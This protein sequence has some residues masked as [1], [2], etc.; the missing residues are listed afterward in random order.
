MAL[1]QIALRSDDIKRSHGLE[2]ISISEILRD[3]AAT[4]EL[5]KL[6]EEEGVLVSNL[7][8]HTI[9]TTTE[10]K[11]EYR[12]CGVI[13]A[14]NDDNLIRNPIDTM[15]IR[16]LNQCT[17]IL[18]GVEEQMHPGGRIVLVTSKSARIKKGGLC[19]LFSASNV[20]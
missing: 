18:S 6:Q 11:Q 10:P 19:V 16:A 2:I 7:I 3:A 13:R 5:K 9:S 12:D 1:A 17:V 14:P 8:F 15:I 20:S 4:D